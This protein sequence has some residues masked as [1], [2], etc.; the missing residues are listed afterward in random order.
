MLDSSLFGPM[1]GLAGIVMCGLSVSFFFAIASKIF[2]SP[3][4]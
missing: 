1:E 2:A 4:L 3:K